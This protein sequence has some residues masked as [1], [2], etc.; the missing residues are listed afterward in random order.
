MIVL[1]PVPLKIRSNAG[2]SNYT[3]IGDLITSRIQG[4]E[5]KLVQV[6]TPAGLFPSRYEEPEST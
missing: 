6:F 4:L 2:T 1:V 3:G 5:Q